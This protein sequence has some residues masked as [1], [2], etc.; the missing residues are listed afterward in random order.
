MDTVPATSAQP[1]PGPDDAPE[2]DTVVR[3]EA[4][5]TTTTTGRRPVPLRRLLATVL[6]ATTA[7]YALYQGIQQVL[8]PLQV[9]SIDPDR[10]VANLAI[11]SSVT[12]ITSL[13]ALPIGGAL[14][15]RTRGRFGRRTPWLVAMAVVSGVLVTVMG[16]ADTF[17]ALLVMYA[18]LWFTANAYQGSWAAIMPD[19]VPANRRGVASSVIGFGTP[20]GIMIGVNYVAN[21]PHHVAYASLGAFLVVATLV[22]VLGAPEGP[23][24]APRPART[25]TSFAMTAISFFSAFK[26]RNFALAFVSRFLLYLAYFSVFGYMLYILTDRVGVENLP[27]HKAAVAVGILTTINSI[28]WIGIAAVIGWLADVFQRRKLFVGVAAV[29]MAVA[30]AVPIIWPTWPGMIVFTLMV[31]LFKGAYVAVDLALMSLVLPNRDDEGRDMALLSIATGTPALVSG[32]IAGV[33]ITV[34]GGYT[35]LFVFGACCALC[36]GLAVTPI[37]GVR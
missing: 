34:T 22:L 36:A 18:A 33:I 27:G 30:M 26:H 32:V 6:P 28:A 13:I 17:A 2:G 10:K 3:M 1:S 12:A 19:R 23:Y 35:G 37:K 8:I 31:G 15:D 11:L 7:M 24:T 20:L 29:G 9:E 16:H 14:S 4:A 25:R 5:T 21:V